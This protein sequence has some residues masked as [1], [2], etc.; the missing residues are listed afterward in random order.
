[1]RVRLPQSLARQRQSGQQSEIDR[2]IG[3]GDDIGAARGPGDVHTIDVAGRN[4]PPRFVAAV[5]VDANL[6]GLP[7][8]T[9]ATE[10][11][12]ATE[13]IGMPPGY[14]AVIGGDTEI[15][16]ESFGYLAESLLLA[17]VFVY[18]DSGRAVRVVHRSA[19]DHAVAAVSIVAWPACWR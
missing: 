10:A 11:T 1:V 2:P 15:M 9:A 8:G 3:R 17:I 18:L 5:T 4:C 7:L 6:D 19:V 13:K 14:K 16:V 12:R